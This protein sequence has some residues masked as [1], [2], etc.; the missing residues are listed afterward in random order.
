MSGAE[1]KAA[2]RVALE[3]W[4]QRDDGGRGRFDAR[5]NA[6]L[7]DYGRVCRGVE[8]HENKSVRA[9]LRLVRTEGEE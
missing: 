8:A 6:L 5:L 9:T 4:K 3:A 1:H 7:D 2:H